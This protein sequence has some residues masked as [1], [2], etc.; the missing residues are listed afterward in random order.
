M[1]FVFIIIFLGI[2]TS[3][4]SKKQILNYARKHIETLSSAEFQ[5]RGYTHDG[6]MKAENYLAQVY[7][8]TGLTP[9][10]PQYRQ[11]VEFPVNILHSADLK[12][13]GEELQFGHEYLISPNA[14][15]SEIEAEVFLIPNTIFD[16]EIQDQNEIFKLMALNAGK[17]PVL[18]FRGATG[19][20]LTKLQQF[21]TYLD[22]E[23]TLYEFP[24]LIQMHDKLVHGIA[25]EQDNFMIIQTTSQISDDDR[26][27]LKTETDLNPNFQSRNIVGKIAGTQSDSA[28]FITAHYDHLGRVNETFFPGAN[29][30][31]SGVSMLLNLAAHF[32]KHPPKHDLYFYAM[33]GEEAGLQG[34]FTAVQNLPLPQDKI[35]FLINLDIFGTGDDG[36]QVVNSSI[37]N[38]EY[39]ILNNINTENNLVK[40]IKKRGE[41]CNSD[42]CPFYLKGVRCFFIYT[43]GGVSH[44][45]DPLDGSETLPLTDYYDIFRLLTQFIQQL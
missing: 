44:Y 45:H 15:T 3:C 34:A 29:D 21:T 9:V 41:A 24:A 8:T 32:K 2:L 10:Y 16:L 4:S 7:A 33:T 40:Q 22:Q 12:L 5:G 20:L 36:I 6:L 28:I 43:L 31:A 1:R 25:N 37:F 17:I 13:N 26:I 27:Y 30:N 38:K 18:D 11:K 23:K 42:H 39:E 35:K 14:E 19:D